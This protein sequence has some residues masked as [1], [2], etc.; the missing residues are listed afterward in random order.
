MAT[1]RRIELSSAA[2][3][4]RADNYS[5]QMQ[6]PMNL[7]SGQ[8]SVAV[9]Q[10]AVW[11]TYQNI[12]PT[13][14][15]QQFSF[16]IDGGSNVYT[17]T[18]RPGSYSAPDLIAAMEEQMNELSGTADNDDED[19]KASDLIVLEV[20]EATLGFRLTLGTDCSINLA[21]NGS[22]LY[23]IFGAE[24]VEYDTV[25]TTYFPNQADITNGI[26]GLQLHCNL[27][28]SCFN[29]VAS[30]ILFSF[31]IDE[32]PGY[33]YSVLVPYPQFV[34]C[35]TN[36]LNQIALRITDNLG[37]PVDF[38]NGPDFQ[39]NASTVTLLLRRDSA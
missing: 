17:A 9:G 1:M 8:W 39:T 4:Q 10:I 35:T 33:L 22:Q 5:V 20:S 26:T 29:G 25:G 15:N 13:Y 24:A 16:S 30:D 38:V 23:R 31:S 11:H 2:A 12:N 37:R 27:A 14:G 6:P 28:D 34:P 3:G 32:P 7:G 19:P 18:L 36:V 21:A